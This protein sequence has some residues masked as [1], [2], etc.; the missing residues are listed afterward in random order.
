MVAT[1][2]ATDQASGARPVSTH[3][4]GTC[5]AGGDGGQGMR[6]RGFV[7]CRRF[8][9]RWLSCHLMKHSTHDTPVPVVPQSGPVGQAQWSNNSPPAAQLYRKGATRLSPPLTEESSAWAWL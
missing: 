3:T 7:M 9:D 1:R 2:L 5:G 8:C 6:R 4:P